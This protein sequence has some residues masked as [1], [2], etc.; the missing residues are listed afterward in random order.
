MKY[1]APCILENHLFDQLWIGIENERLQI[2]EQPLLP[3]WEHHQLADYS[4]IALEVLVRLWM[5]AFIRI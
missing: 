2:L 4:P 1:V 5:R 3:I